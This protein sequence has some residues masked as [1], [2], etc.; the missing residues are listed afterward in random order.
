MVAIRRCLADHGS[1]SLRGA[2]LYTSGEPCVMCMGAIVWCGIGR[3]VFAADRQPDQSDHDR[4]RRGGGAGQMESDQDHRRRLCRRGDEAFAE[5]EF[6]NSTTGGDYRVSLLNPAIA[7]RPCSASS[8]KKRNAW[9][10][11]LPRPGG[12]CP[13]VPVSTMWRSCVPGASEYGRISMK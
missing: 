7:A 10:N 1:A 13:P 5:I 8:K 6:A 2:T 3:L 4:Q 9:L 12:S 11:G